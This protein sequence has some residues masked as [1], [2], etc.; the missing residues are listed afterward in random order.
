MP[1]KKDPLLEELAETRDRLKNRY[2]DENGRAPVIC[3]DDALREM[4]KR[5][6]LKKSDFKAIQGIGDVFVERYAEDFLR[7]IYKHKNALI[8]EV[9]VSRKS[10]RAL[11]DYKDRL[12]NISRRNRNLYTGKLSKKLGVDLFN[13]HLEEDLEAFMLQIRTKPLRLT[14]IKSENITEDEERFYRRL[15]LLYREINREARETGSYSLNIAYPFI[16]GKL[17]GEGFEVKAPLMFFPVVLERK[18][19]DFY[20]RL[21][22]EKDVR[23][24]RDLILAN[25][26]FNNFES[27][28]AMPDSEKLTVKNIKS[29]VLPFFE[30]N[31]LSIKDKG[32]TKGYFQ[33]FEDTVKKD[34]KKI[35][36]GDLRLKKYIVLGKYRIYSSKIQEDITAILEGKT[37]NDLL[38][39]LLD[40]PYKPYDYS[41]ENPFSGSGKTDVDEHNLTYINDLNYSQEKVLDLINKHDKLV[42]WGPPGTGKSQ[43]I[44]SLIAKQVEKGE[45]VLLVSEKKAALDVIKSRLGYA[46]KFALFMDD[47][48]DKEAFY[49][50]IKN[51]I[52]PMPPVRNHNNDRSTIDAAIN[53]T[54]KKLKNMHEAFYEPSLN[55][56]ALFKFY[57]RYLAT[58]KLKDDLFPETVHHA[59]KSVFGSFSFHFIQSLEATFDD[60][61]KLKRILT[62]QYMKDTYPIIEKMNFKL[63]RSEKLK[64]TDF[65]KAFEAFKETY[66]RA[67]FFTKRKKRKR[68]IREHA[69]AIDFLFEKKRHAKTFIKDIIKD[70]EFYELIKKHYSSF[71]RAEYQHSKLSEDESRYVKMLLYKEPFHSIESVHLRHNDIFDALYTG[72]IEEFEAKNQ[73]KVYDIRHYHELM[74][75]LGGWIE[76]K[77]EMSSES[78]SMAL[79]QDALNFSNSKRIMDIKRRIEQTRKLSVSKFIDEHQL[80]LFSNI[81]VWMMTPEVVSEIVPLNFAMFDLVIFDEASQMF[82]EKAIPT[83]YRAKKVVIAGDTKQLRP[84]SLGQGR[85]AVDDDLLEEDEELDITLDAQSLL[86]LARYKYTETILN[87]HYRSRY[88]ELIGFSNYAFYDGKLIV[89]PNQEHPKAP[90]IEYIVCEDG[91]W[92]RRQNLPEAK[93][94]VEIIKRTIRE[95]SEDE[96][97]GVITFN[98]QQRNLIEDLLDET[99]FSNSKYARL[100]EREM[101]RFED[102][103]DKSLFVKNIENVQGDERDIIIFSTAYAKNAE[104]KF[105]R[106]FG[107]L[108]NEGGQNRLNVAISRAKRKIYMVTSF[109]PESFHVEDLKSVGPKK[110]K[111]YLQ[112]CKHIS[113][114]NPEGARQVLERLTDTSIASQGITLNTLQED[115]AKRL[116]RDKLSYATNIGI[117][118]YTIDFGIE[119][120]SA[121]TYKLGILCDVLSENHADDVRDSYYHQEKYLRARGWRLYRVFAPNWYKDANKEM[122]AIRKILRNEA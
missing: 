12:T 47:A 17:Q 88:E 113:D 24:N 68:F 43:T 26:K 4:A 5:K 75:E 66:D 64:R 106:Q 19:Y 70:D 63:T 23:I 95:K 108:N 103:E 69:D 93:K 14:D 59:F 48:Q 79:Y 1:L 60:T 84:S 90:P 89:S 18:G 120:D 100:I 22:R 102:G 40:N 36:K 74:E 44:T 57:E 99:L 110:L 62:Y 86:D 85:L 82:V 54:F 27:I 32:D 34:F 51:H 29:V 114:K 65:Y 73:D 76:E 115:V 52:D 61:K 96:T 111:E 11:S 101:N 3:T 94:V 35:K 46:S 16:Q 41:Q 77:K 13:S 30:E 31:H 39:G 2:K 116:E 53:K 42:I 104:G 20:L 15:T 87:Y 58:N 121:N 80:E 56:E 10:K 55:D 91:L 28:N 109:Y 112:Y 45:N 21:D 81:K 97:L 83:I 8:E 25:N 122:R 37:F 38:E 49:S 71:E 72:F 7:V 9:N 98:V 78:F 107:W 118:K 119:G 67:F 50:Q 117:G 92:D 105:L 6:P 33:P